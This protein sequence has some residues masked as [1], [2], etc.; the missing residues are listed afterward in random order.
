MGS[1]NSWKFVLVVVLVLAVV[2]GLE[3]ATFRNPSILAQ[4]VRM[5]ADSHLPQ[6]LVGLAAPLVYAWKR[7]FGEWSGAGPK[8]DDLARDNARLKDEQA[9]LRQDV[10]A[11]D[12][13]RE[14]ETTRQR[15]EIARI[16]GD[17]TALNDR[18][19]ANDRQLVQAV[20][21]PASSYV[22]GLTPEQIR[23]QSIAFNR[24]H[25]IEGME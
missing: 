19:A 14:Q 16:Q 9:R 13:W 3:I 11:L 22:D 4:A 8:L 25:G 12:G 24:E 1:S 18:I 10:S 5:S 20:Q 7:L 17:I 21:A 23:E 2:V 15:Q 6:W